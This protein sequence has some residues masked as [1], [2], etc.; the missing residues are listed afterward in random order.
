MNGL[1]YEDLKTN[2]DKSEYLY[3]LET[4]WKRIFKEYNQFTYSQKARLNRYS[5][6]Y[7]SEGLTLSQIMSTPKFR[8]GNALDRGVKELFDKIDRYNLVLNKLDEMIDDIRESGEI[9]PI[10]NGNCN[11]YTFSYIFNT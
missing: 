10:V 2:E 4:E 11:K 1:R 7:E 3:C 6:I 9:L 5:A 8:N